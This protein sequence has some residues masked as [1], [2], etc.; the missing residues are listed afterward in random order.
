MTTTPLKTFI[1]YAREDRAS[2]D[3]LMGHLSVFARSGAAEFWYDREI[4][5]GKDWDEEIRFNLKN[6]D[7][8]LLLI[9][10]AFFNSDYIHSVEL[11]EALQRDRD[12]EARVVPVILKKCLWHKYPE[13]ARLQA[14]PAEAK[15]VYDK[16][17]WPDPDDAFYDIGEG[18]DRILEDP[19]TEAR[20]QQ[21]QARIEAETAAEQQRQVEEARLHKQQEAA[22]KKREAAEREAEAARIAAEAKEREERHRKVEAE[23]QAKEREERKRR[24][25]AA[26]AF[27]EMVPVEGG[28]FQLGGEHAVTVPD[29]EIGKYPVTQ[30]QWREIMG[31]NPSHFKG[32][33]LP[34]ENISWDDAQA[35]I[36]KLNKRFPG[37]HF[38]LPSEAEWEYAARG[39][40]LSKGYEYAGSNKLDEVGWYWENSGDKPL[41]G[42]WD[43]EK[44]Q[45]NNCRTHP[46]G[47]K[48]ANE[49]GLH[50]MSG[51]VWEWCADDWHS[52][53]E[54][55]PTDGSA[56]V[57]SPQRGSPRVLRGGS[58]LGN[59][60]SCRVSLRNDY[61]PDSR[62]SGIGFRVAFVP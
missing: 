10:P 28:S 19:E 34:V 13:L 55:R 2:L 25:E 1:I 58:W 38:R 15:P 24:E 46:V 40:L 5:G 6:A 12:K 16:N 22:R 9:S 47:Q 53:N 54:G 30:K 27:I 7:I 23:R 49:L 43:W 36:N 61:I 39:G 45:K 29:F 41:S 31:N 8:V 42:K 62:G 14:L 20:R 35:F 18:F 57:D 32:D 11:T 33:D 21:K 59:A 26:Q 44:I 52:D 17:S 37:R 48:K 60:G 50:D 56:W 4:T 51:N 3:L